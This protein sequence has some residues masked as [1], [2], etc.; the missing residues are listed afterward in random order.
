[1]WLMTAAQIVRQ[2][3]QPVVEVIV[4]NLMILGNGMLQPALWKLRNAIRP[5][6]LTPPPFLASSQSQ[7]SF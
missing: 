1:M 4:I 5:A 3:N 6:A 2:G 7:L